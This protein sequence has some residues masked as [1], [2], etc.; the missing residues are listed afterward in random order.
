QESQQGRTGE[1]SDRAK[2][3]MAL[4]VRSRR[5]VFR[6]VL[7]QFEHRNRLPG[8]VL[9]LSEIDRGRVAINNSRA[10]HSAAI[11]CSFEL[12]LGGNRT[13]TKGGGDTGKSLAIET[14]DGQIDAEAP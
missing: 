11:Q 13:V 8:I 4:R 2:N 7:D 12:I 10:A 6:G 3:E 14:V 1:N 9:D 5:L